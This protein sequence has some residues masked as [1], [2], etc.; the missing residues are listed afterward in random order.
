MT[1]NP[2]RRLALR[3]PARCLQNAAS[4]V[5]AALLAVCAGVG[6]AEERIAVLAWGG[7]P[8]DQ[9]T[10]ERYRELADA[11]F[12]HNYSSFGSA[13]AMAAALDL[14][15]TV[16]LK[17]L[18][19]IPELA[20]E[21]E[22]IAERF[23]SHP[24]T[25]GYYL[26]DEPSASLF[27]ELAGWT[28]RIQSVDPA[29]PCYINLFPNYATPDQLA[30]ANYQEYLDRFVREVPVPFVSFD[31]YPVIGDKLR[32][33]WFDNLER[34]AK[35]ASAAKKPFWAFALAVAHGPYPIPTVAELRLQVFSNLAYGAQGIQYF[36]YWTFKSS[37][38]DFHEAPIDVNGRRTPVYD[39]V[40]QVNAE[41]RGLSSVFH[42]AR[43]IRLG[44]TGDLPAGTTR[45]QPEAP[46]VAL[47][48]ASGG[49]IVSLLEKEKHR[50]LVVVNRDFR[51]P[52]PVEV[53]LDGSV[54][55]SE[56][57]K[58]GALV[59]IS[60]AKFSTDAGPGDV[61]ILQWEPRS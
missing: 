3:A 12:T 13:D 14:A 50:F 27:A 36:T 8:A 29:N 47:G 59:P 37:D 49:A 25:G 19:S 55:V 35:T 43:V 10:P 34:V 15:Q 1:P 7:P 21:P 31:H 40:K 42:R 53:T 52:L 28:K 56:R 16:G 58:G 44:H 61:V 18:V 6:R 51:Q 46:V 26:R 32:P 30:T 20:K 5:V 45:Y 33:E 23:K 4:L 24:A 22:K 2:H 38:W 9:T 48:T 39:R 60:G 54:P 11:G 41:I 57:R 17:Q